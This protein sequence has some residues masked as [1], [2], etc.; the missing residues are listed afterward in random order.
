MSNSN[1]N[2]LIQE[3]L[4]CSNNLRHYSTIRTTLLS[5]F[6]V[7]NTGFISILYSDVFKIPCNLNIYIKLSGLIVG[8]IFYVVD[9]SN[10]Y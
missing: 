8:I 7:I 4:D 2:P 9:I 3:Y 1:D 5:V 6:I 10:I